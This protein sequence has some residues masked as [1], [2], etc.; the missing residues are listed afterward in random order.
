[1]RLNISPNPLVCANVPG[2]VNSVVYD[3]AAGFLA[4]G[5]EISS[6]TPHVNIGHALAQME[7][8]DVFHCHGLYP[9]GDGYFD[10]S[11][12]RSNDIVLEN[13]LRAKVTVCIS[14]FSANILRH[15][16]HIDP[17]VTR[18][19]IWV[20]D[21]R[22]G[23]DPFGPILFAKAALDANAKPDDMLWLKQ[24]AP[25][26]SLISIANIKGINSTGPLSRSRFLETLNGCS[27][28]LGTT[29]ENNSMATMEAMIMGVPV[30]GYNFGFN[31]E[32]LTSGAGCELVPVG[33]RS[34]LKSALQ[35]VLSNWRDYSKRAREYAGMFDWQPVINELLGIYERVHT[36]A[37]D[38]SVSIVIPCH[39]YERWVGE[40]IQSALAQ[41]V[42][43]EV[44]VVDDCSND[45]SV[46]E[47]LKW[48][49]KL[50]QNKHNV[51]VA[52]TRNI[53]IRAAKG[54]FIVCLD[55]DD[56]M[57]EDFVEKHLKAFKTRAD[58]I[59]VSPI[60]LIDES[61]KETGQFMFKTE[62]R[63]ALHEAGSNQVPSCCMFRKEFWVR[64]GGYESHVQ[65][66]EDAHLWLKI[67]QLGGR[68]Q[69]AS[70]EALMDYRTHSG[71]LSAKGFPNWWKMVGIGYAEPIR[72]RDSHATF[73]VEPGSEEQLKGTLWSLESLKN[74]SWSCQMMEPKNLKESFPWIN[75]GVSR[76]KSVITL[77]AGTILP[78][79][80]LSEYTQQTPPWLKGSRAPYP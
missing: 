65:P 73:I 53:G 15:K 24:N 6:N 16:L 1:M 68:V 57:R 33:D 59:G 63:P 22:R 30:V 27:V 66:A 29:K 42:A 56:R 2:G 77:K 34:A 60:R 76:Q 75:K 74:K 44:I 67:M 32:W 36:T 58:A 39:N 12:S 51:G 26:L 62:P 18:N 46:K 35:K 71:S 38:R 8:I 3:H 70:Q 72:E 80:F 79:E 19:G 13:A 40:A 9:I 49:V 23:G 37:E 5:H 50:I 11:Y 17:V 69:K 54:T 61:G 28:Y 4:Q 47:I 21:Y 43:C 48:P 31:S 52:R 14:E 10:P 25:E 78:T 55:A 7:N 64:A 20:K 41:T 45:H